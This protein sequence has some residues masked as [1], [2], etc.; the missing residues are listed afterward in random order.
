MNRE[1]SVTSEYWSEAAEPRSPVDESCGLEPPEDEPPVAPDGLLP[2]V[3]PL[4]PVPLPEVPGAGGPPV[5]VT[6][7]GAGADQR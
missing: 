5:I 3:P 4:P 1:M 2:V 6:A 7:E